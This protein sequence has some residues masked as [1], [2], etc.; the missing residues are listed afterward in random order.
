MRITTSFVAP[1]TIGV[2]GGRTRDAN[3]VQSVTLADIVPFFFFFS[4][5]F[6][7]L[8]DLENYRTI[9][10]AATEVELYY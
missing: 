5:H 9:F 7:P 10:A 4:F 2:G 3:D 8:N 6:F 1:P